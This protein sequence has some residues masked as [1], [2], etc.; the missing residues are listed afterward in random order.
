M[1]AHRTALDVRETSVIHERNY[2][3]QFES[4][5]RVQPADETSALFGGSAEV[6]LQK[7]ASR[8]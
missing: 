4:H 2:L 8:F 6:Y 1:E 7:T 3:P 5:T